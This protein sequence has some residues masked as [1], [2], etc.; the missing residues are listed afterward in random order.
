MLWLVGDGGGHIEQL[1]DWLELA[2]FVYLVNIYAY[3]KLNEGMAVNPINK[4]KQLNNQRSST[5]K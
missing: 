2:F 1:S 4:H 5:W 3:Y